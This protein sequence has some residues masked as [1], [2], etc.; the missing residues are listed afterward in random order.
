[1]ILKIYLRF[2]YRVLQGIKGGKGEK[3]GMGKEGRERVGRVLGEGVGV[4]VFGY[5]VKGVKEV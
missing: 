4:G 3:G 1:M 2:C 5:G